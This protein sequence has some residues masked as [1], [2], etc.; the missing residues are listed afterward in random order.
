VLAAAAALAG[1]VWLWARGHRSDV[2][3]LFAWTLVG[4]AATAGAV[5]LAG[6]RWF[7][8]DDGA[9]L[10]ALGLPNLLTIARCI[11]VAPTVVLLA[12]EHYGAALFAYAVLTATDV[13]DGMVAR[14]HALQS[15]FGTIVDPL[16]D[17]A[18]TFAVFTV[19]V[20]D[21]LAPAWVY[22]VLTV[23]YAMLFVGSA[24]LSWTVAPIRFRATVPGK[25][26]GVAQALGISIV[27][28]GAG[29][30]GLSPPVSRVVF[31][32]LGIAFASI[33][34]SQAVLGWRHIR[35]RASRRGPAR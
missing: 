31:P 6:A 10:V 13:V 26:V 16:A 25:I 21:G 9:P 2:V 30:G 27:I 18:S 33:V 8:R 12:R 20:V 35:G 11:L 4:G 22:V 14:R 28:A 24:V 5:V 23:R 7:R 29:S 17:V 19:L 32:F 3:P 34:V 1:G 15:E